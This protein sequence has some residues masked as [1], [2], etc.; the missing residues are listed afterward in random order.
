MTFVLVK[1]EADWADELDVAGLVILTKAMWESYTNRVKNYTDFEFN[2]GS[3]QFIDFKDANTFL[4]H[5]NVTNINEADVAMF[6]KHFGESYD[7]RCL[8]TFGH[9][10]LITSD[11][12]FGMDCS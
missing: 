11:E 4:S 9:V 8:V 2:I 7:S 10:S 3:N 12:F 5:F 6:V 1:F